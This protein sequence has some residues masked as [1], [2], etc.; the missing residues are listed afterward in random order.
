M[1]NDAV[2]EMSRWLQPLHMLG[3]AGTVA[4]GRD[5]W[6]PVLLVAMA[7]HCKALSETWKQLG[8]QFKNSSDVV[9]A[10]VDCTKNKQVCTEFDVSG[11]HPFDSASGVGSR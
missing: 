2:I 3:M 6:L 1:R 5:V 11:L 4:C 7:G 10:H 8:V 9:I